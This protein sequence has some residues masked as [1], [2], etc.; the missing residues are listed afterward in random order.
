MLESCEFPWDPQAVRDSGLVFLAQHRAEVY[1]AMEEFIQMR[2]DAYTTLDDDEL[3]SALTPHLTWSESHL[4]KLIRQV[5]TQRLSVQQ[6]QAI[7]GLFDADYVRATA[8][9]L[10]EEANTEAFWKHPPPELEALNARCAVFARTMGEHA[11]RLRVYVSRQD[12]EA[13]H[14]ERQRQQFEGFAK[15]R[16]RAS[17][18]TARSAA[19]EHFATLGLKRNASLQEVK[20]AYRERV[21][22]HHPDQGGTVQDFLRVQ[23]AYE[24][25]LTQVF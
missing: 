1:L 24:Y 6:R 7:Y 23:E 25:L 13:R 12:F 16:T 19:D 18:K 4:R 10:M 20:L 3:R 9:Y 5:Q 14:G 17:G 21:K 11:R 2:M 22:Q 8:R 15:G